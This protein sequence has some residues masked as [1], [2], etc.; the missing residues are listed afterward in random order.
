MVGRPASRVTVTLR[1]LAPPALVAWHVKFVPAVS[2]LTVAAS[3]PLL[4][5][6]GD[7]SSSTLQ[8]NCTS[9]VY[10]P[11]LPVAPATTAS[12][13]GGVESLSGGGVTE[14]VAVAVVR[15]PAR[16]VAVTE[17]VFSPNVAVSREPP[18][19]TGPSH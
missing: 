1:E 15:F 13:T 19:A 3:Q 11:S 7:S 5:L 16:S 14:Y 10:Q 18:L 4:A 8:L 2:V 9:L 6:T 12:I 17:N